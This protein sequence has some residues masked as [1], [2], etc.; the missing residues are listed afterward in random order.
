MLRR[1][2]VV[3]YLLFLKSQFFLF[4]L[5]RHLTKVEEF[6]GIRRV[7]NCCTFYFGG[8][9]FIEFFINKGNRELLLV[10]I[11][12]S[13]AASLLKDVQSWETLYA[14]LSSVLITPVLYGWG[15]IL[16]QFM[17]SPVL[18]CFISRCTNL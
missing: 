11:C 10:T 16:W 5:S 18:V 17:N 15:T 6:N 1:L 8:N 2:N 3:L 14:R 13:L 9:E 7:C 4:I 12:F